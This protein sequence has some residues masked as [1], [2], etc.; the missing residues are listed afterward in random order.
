MYFKDL[1]FIFTNSFEISLEFCYNGE[2]CV[3]II[4]ILLMVQLMSK[5]STQ[6]QEIVQK[7]AQFS[8]FFMKQLL[9]YF[10]IFGQKIIY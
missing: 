6:L 4:E 3:N 5:I 2:I 8:I 10:Q 7:M 9:G 1:G